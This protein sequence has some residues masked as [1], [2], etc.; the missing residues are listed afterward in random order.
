M[1]GRRLSSGGIF[2][3]QLDQSNTPTGLRAL[4]T[5]PRSPQANSLCERVLGT[6]R[7][8][9]LDFLIP[10][11]EKHLRIVM[12]NWVNH[13]NRN[14]PHASL[15]PEIPDPPVDLPVTP[16]KRRHRIPTRLKVVARPVPGGLHHRI[17]LGREGCM[18]FCGS[19]RYQIQGTHPSPSSTLAVNSEIPGGWIDLIRRDV[20]MLATT[21]HLLFDNG[22]EPG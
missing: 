6:L 9:C 18:N 8:E 13:C 19:F 1:S 2:Y 4:R 17:W 16:H 21:V 15:G 7:R 5:P 11:K 12:K 10:L 3:S 22:S 14:R 20:D